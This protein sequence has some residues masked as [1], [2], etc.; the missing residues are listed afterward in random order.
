MTLGGRDTDNCKKKAHWRSLNHEESVEVESRAET[1]GP[2][3]PATLTVVNINI[4]RFRIVEKKIRLS[5]DLMK[6][7]K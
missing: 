7:L 6:W 2:V 3:N 4:W 1:T 5:K